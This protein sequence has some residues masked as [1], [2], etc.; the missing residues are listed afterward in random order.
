MHYVS[1]SATAFA[2]AHI[3]GFFMIHEDENPL[4]KGTTGCG[5]VLDKGVSSTVR[6]VEKDSAVAITLN[7]SPAEAPVTSNLVKQL[8]DDPIHVSTVSEI[9]VGSGF[10][11]SAAGALGTAY[12]LNSLFSLNHTQN[13]LVEK[14]HVAEVL[15]GG[16]LGDVEAIAHRGV[17]IRKAPGP[18]T[19]TGKLDRIPCS[20][21]DIYCV[22]LGCI[23]TK[24]VLATPATVE[25]I[26]RAGNNAMKFLMEQPSV[27]RFMEASKEFALNVGLLSSRAEDV[28]EA[29]ESTGGLASQAMLGDTVF[30]IADDKCRE[31]VLKT[32]GEFGDVLKCRVNGTY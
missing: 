28:I 7:G 27:I 21:F 18:L 17:V 16:G 26:N 12:A 24:E 29:V 25:C 4:F 30:A 23:S 10:G 20:S 8:S 19:T 22:V 5:L 2:P 1:D 6:I 32:L 11:A 13:E 14:V 31:D 15:E 9:P 3:T